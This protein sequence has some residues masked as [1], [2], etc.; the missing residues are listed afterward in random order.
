MPESSE[1]TEEKT[2]PSH[3]EKPKRSK[4]SVALDWG[5]KSLIGIIPAL[6]T[7]YFAMQQAKFESTVEIARINAKAGAGYETLAD[8]VKKLDATAK[9]HE[10][11]ISELSA[12]CSKAHASGDG[13]EGPVAPVP[14]APRT[15]PGRRGGSAPA[16]EGLHGIGTVGLGAGSGITLTPPDKLFKKSTPLRL[17]DTLEGAAALKEAEK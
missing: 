5:G 7:G 17:P 3:H 9:E 14:P 10:R 15:R 4:T 6:A 16:A 11:V 1:K 12:T 8:A 2:E 13:D